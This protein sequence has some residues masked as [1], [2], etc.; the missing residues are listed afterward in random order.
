MW[1]HPSRHPT[2]G[3]RQPI[4]SVRR[5]SRIKEKWRTAL[6]RKCPGDR[7][8]ASVFIPMAYSEAVVRDPPVVIGWSHTHGGFG[9]SVHGEQIADAV[10]TDIPA[11]FYEL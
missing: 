8:T 7:L 11:E 6:V 5:L 9:Q 3:S 2:P 4:I 1:F 10:P